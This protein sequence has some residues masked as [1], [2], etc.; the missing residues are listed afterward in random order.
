MGYELRTVEKEHYLLI[1]ISGILDQEASD[2]MV[3]EVAEALF[4]SQHYKLLL[5]VRKLEVQ[6]SVLEDH[7][8][9]S[10]AAKQFAGKKHR[11]ASLS[12][13]SDQDSNEFFEVVC[14]NRGMNYRAFCVE[15]E[16][17]DFL[18]R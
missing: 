13:D 16:A 14:V 10:Y 17:I 8:Q 3:E 12:L 6:T 11:I 15:Q 9:A 7:L 18:M 4:K 5:D 2:R 1:N